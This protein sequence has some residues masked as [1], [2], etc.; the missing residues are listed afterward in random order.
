MLSHD[1]SGMESSGILNEEV[2]SGEMDLAKSSVVD[3][4]FELTCIAGEEL[5]S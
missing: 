4:K 3:K 2:I 1:I 5:G